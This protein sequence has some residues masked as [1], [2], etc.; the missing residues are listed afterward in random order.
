MSGR[1]DPVWKFTFVPSVN[2]RERLGD[3][4]IGVSKLLQVP[5]RITLFII[6]Y[7]TRVTLSSDLFH[8]AECK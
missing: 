3:L 7:L 6:Y 2:R 8:C 4:Q 1:A 5:I